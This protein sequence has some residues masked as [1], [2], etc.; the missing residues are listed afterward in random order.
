MDVRDIA[1]RLE[2]AEGKGV[3]DCILALEAQDPGR[4][5]RVER[6]GQAWLLDAGPD[7]F[8]T[9]AY[10]VGLE[11]EAVD[12]R[13]I[14]R[15]TDFYHTRGLLPR[16]ELSPYAHP[17]VLPLLQRAGYGIAGFKD[18][19]VR[20]MNASASEGAALSP[21]EAS[22]E[23]RE[24]DRA[25]RAQVERAGWMIARG[26]RNGEEP[27]QAQAFGIQA[28][29]AQPGARAFWAYLDKEP[30]GGGVMA[31]A[32]GRIALF[33][34]STLPKARRRGVQTELML[35]RLRAGL[36]MGAKL[37][38]IQAAPGVA[39]RRNAERMGFWLAYTKL[40]CIGPKPGKV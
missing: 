28:L 12:D 3:G 17:S 38:T 10:A 36:A 19:L 11:E 40:E 24:I 29:I 4:C 30:V 35:A 39:T 1:R 37:A 22:V 15:I 5:V 13:Y 27:T 20:E 34:A 25:D 16:I 8:L 9:R 32:S 21:R 14:E 7:S 6:L 31:Y 33:A 26:F 18:V 2:L 23:V